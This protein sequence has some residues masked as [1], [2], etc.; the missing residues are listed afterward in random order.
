MA[1]EAG[2]DRR[3][4]AVPEPGAVLD[5]AVLGPLRI[6]VGGAP[7]ALTAR[8]LRAL[9]LRLLVEPGEA[10]GVDQLAEAVWGPEL[11]ANHGTT[12]GV[13]L[14][15]LRRVLGRERIVHL[16]GR[17]QLVLA[18]G[19]LDVATFEDLAASGRAAASSGNHGVAARLLEQALG[20][21]RGEPAALSAEDPATL[22]EGRRLAELCL[23]TREDL[24]DAHLALGA[25]AALVGELEQFVAAEPLRERAQRQLMLALHRSGRSAEAL[26]AFQAFRSRLVEEL[27]LEPSR[28]LADLERQV[29]AQDVALAWRPAALGTALSAGL[30]SLPPALRSD[31]H[32]MVGRERELDALL[33]ALD[34]AR[35]GHLRVLSIDGE[36]G[37]GKSRLLAELARTAATRGHLVALGRCD[38]VA[39]TPYR[40]IVE[41]LQHLVEVTPLEELR[42]MLHGVG[43]ELVRIVPEIGYRLPEVQ[44]ARPRELDGERYYFFDAVATFIGRAAR[45]GPVVLVFDD[46]QWADRSTVDALRHLLR[47]LDGHGVL[48]ALAFRTGEVTGEH[49]LRDAVLGEDVAGP[50]RRVHLGALTEA[51]VAALLA[52]AQPALG[53]QAVDPGLLHARSAGNPFVARELLRHLA[54]SGSSL[55]RAVPVSVA[56]LIDQRVGRLGPEARWF[57][58]C[59]AVAAPGLDLEVLA[60]ASGLALEAAARVVDDAVRA[61]VLAPS[62]PGQGLEF[63]H[64]LIPDALRQGL[65]ELQ[66]AEVHRRV[67]EAIEASVAESM[68]RDLSV[69]NLAYHWSHASTTSELARTVGY[70][71]RA[72]DRAMAQLAPAEACAWFRQGLEVVAQETARVDRLRCELLVSL[73]D[74]QRQSGDPSYRE[75]LLEAGRLANEVGDHHNLV[76]AALANSRGVHSA[77]GAV[78]EERLQLID[79][80]LE[81]VGPGDGPERARLLALQSLELSW[82]HDH[83][84]R[85]AIAAEALAL[86]ER[87]GD[88]AALVSV[89]TTRFVAIH[90]PETLEDRF[91]SSQKALE[92]AVALDDPVLQSAATIEL[93]TAAVQR[94]DRVTADRAIFHHYALA[95]QLEQ[96]TLRWSAA[97]LRAEW[98]LL[99]GDPAEAERLADRAYALGEASGQPDAF[100]IWANQIGEVRYLQGRS[101]E[102]VEVMEAIVDDNP[103]IAA[104]RTALAG[105]FC[106][107]DRIDDARRV[108]APDVAAGFRTIPRDVAWL[109]AMLSAADAVYGIGDADAAPILLEHLS[110]FAAQYDFMGVSSTGSVALRLARLATTLRRRPEAERWFAMGERACLELEARHEL[111]RLRLDWATLLLDQGD[112][113]DRPRAVELLE[114]ALASAEAHGYGLVASRSR[115]QLVHA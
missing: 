11:P 16:D 50:L 70:A 103:G 37:A 48:M 108:L 33:H 60:T 41:L 85:E 26:R 52:D 13:H 47:S 69:E 97:F 101:H 115:A 76:R 66:T 92:L 114:A 83:E 63:T 78:D 113:D 49:P 31:E 51:D 20:L 55:D 25:H 1:A 36:A 91:A 7:V 10:V 22:A 72:G 90:L 64:A 56:A 102:I 30:G 24:F 39:A 5:L 43:E 23:A 74:A 89:L 40:P 59:V 104:F 80:A 98:A 106:D 58:T 111:A 87:L 68:R 17:Y 27:G 94:V 73:G 86:A 57:L 8:T 88:P 9:L 21:V 35:Q 75:T 105:C 93:A 28:E 77:S 95:E 109:A 82:H 99:Q 18:G 112:A 100:A 79:R 19:E 54:A 45:R 14:S 42:A 110:P 61:G 53:G 71:R 32:G 62:G 4:A 67:A 44:P 6:A 38:P 2:G 96:P 84:R 65:G 15:R 81:V 3:S 107:L 29:L 34:E 46:L 12:L